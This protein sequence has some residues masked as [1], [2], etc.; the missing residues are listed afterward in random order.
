MKQ[1]TNLTQKTPKRKGPKSLK[2]RIH[3]HLADQNDI[4][5]EDDLRN[6]KIGEDAFRED[7]NA[8][9]AL[10]EDLKKNAELT[11]AIGERKVTSPWNILTEEDK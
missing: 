6:V 3:K 11:E 2:D 7:A 10:A 9:Q 8:K 5:T 4:I 1:D